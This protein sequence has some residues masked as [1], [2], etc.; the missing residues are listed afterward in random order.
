MDCIEDGLLNADENRLRN[1]LIEE[2]E[3][4]ERR[5]IQINSPNTKLKRC[6]F[7]NLTRSKFKINK[8]S[9]SKYNFVTFLPL[10]LML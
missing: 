4:P 6:L 1:T 7:C 9:T 2:I 5:I 10:N 3:A 8:V